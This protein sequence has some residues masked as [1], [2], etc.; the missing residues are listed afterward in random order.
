MQAT[1]ESAQACTDCALGEA[2]AYLEGSF[3]G[4]GV[5]KAAAKHEQAGCMLELLGQG[6]HLAVQLQDL[7]RARPRQSEG[8]AGGSELTDSDGSVAYAHVDAGC[9]LVHARTDSDH[10][11]PC[12]KHHL[13][14]CPTQV[15]LH[16]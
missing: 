12:P 13:L 4:C 14:C 16:A 1:A 9:R 2:S 8:I 3:E 5:I 7:L 6:Q 11:S 15:C 10:E